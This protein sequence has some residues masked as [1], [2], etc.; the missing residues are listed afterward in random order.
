M[1]KL[2]SWSILSPISLDI[3]S[4]SIGFSFLRFIEAAIVATHVKLTYTYT[5]SKQEMRKL[6]KGKRDNFLKKDR[7]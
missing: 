7:K 1:N 4:F 5:L 2:T 6:S 3:S